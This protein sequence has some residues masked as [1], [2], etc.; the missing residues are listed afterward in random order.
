MDQ[1]TRTHMLPKK[2]TFNANTKR[3]QTSMPTSPTKTPMHPRKTEHSYLT[4]GLSPSIIKI[5]CLKIYVYSKKMPC[6]V[7]SRTHGRSQ[8]TLPTTHHGATLVGRFETHGLTSDW[9]VHEVTYPYDVYTQEDAYTYK[10]K[11]TWSLCVISAGSARCEPGRAV[12][13]GDDCISCI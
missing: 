7:Q 4:A 5:E 1:Q 10:E 6:V 8:S 12:R 13:C 9:P 2:C 11:K 3:A